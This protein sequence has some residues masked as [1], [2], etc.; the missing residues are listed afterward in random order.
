MG[1]TG[2]PP[3]RNSLHDASLQSPA[4]PLNITFPT[5]TATYQVC[6]Y[7]DI[8]LQHINNLVLLSMNRPPADHTLRLLGTLRDCI[9]DLALRTT[10][11]SGFPGESKGAHEEL[12][13]FSDSFGFQ[14]GGAFA[15]SEE[16]GTPA[17][18]FPEQVGR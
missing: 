8:P 2:F 3:S 11:I 10:F 18:G 1:A 7:I 17:A 16:D 6:K 15:Y 12:A 14:R 9:P 4:F 13:E 5:P